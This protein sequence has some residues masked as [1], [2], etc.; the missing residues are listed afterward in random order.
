MFF[1]PVVRTRAVVPARRSFDRNFER[2]IDEAFFRPAPAATA[3][4]QEGDKA[5]RYEELSAIDAVSK[6]ARDD[7]VAPAA[8]GAL[9]MMPALGWASIM[10]ARLTRHLPLITLSA[11][12][13]TMYS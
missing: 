9:W 8:L 3:K 11:S 1:A 12:R 2:F 10:R 4:V 7:A 6:Q 5:Q 13:I